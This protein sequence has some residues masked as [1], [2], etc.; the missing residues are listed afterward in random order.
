VKEQERRNFKGRIVDWTTM[1][2][3]ALDSSTITHEASNDPAS[4]LELA[5]QLKE[6]SLSS[7]ASIR[8]LLPVTCAM[9]PRAVCIAQ[10]IF[11]CN[12]CDKYRLIMDANGRYRGKSQ[13][14]FSIRYRC[15]CPNKSVILRRPISCEEQEAQEVSPSDSQSSSVSSFSHS[16]GSTTTTTT[17]TA[18][19]SCRKMK[20][21]VYN[22]PDSDSDSDSDSEDPHFERLVK[23][24]APPTTLVATPV[25][26][27]LAAPPTLGILQQSIRAPT[28]SIHRSIATQTDRTMSRINNMPSISRWSKQTAT[29]LGVRLN[30]VIHNEEEKGEMQRLTKKQRRINL[31]LFG[32]ALMSLTN[33]TYFKR[34]LKTRG[35]ALVFCTF[36]YLCEWKPELFQ[37][38]ILV[39]SRQFLR[40]HVFQPWKFQK[41]IDTNAAGG[42]N[43]ESCNS[44]RNDV[45]ELAS[46]GVIPHGTTIAKYAKLLEQHAVQAYGLAI[47]VEKTRHGPSLS[48]DLDTLLR[49]IICGY[50]LDKFAA[51]ASGHPPVL[52][53]HTLDG[54][55]LTSN[56]GHVT[57][58]TKI[59]DPRAANPMTGI[60]IG[61]SGFFQSRDLCYPA[62]IVFGKDCK[63]LYSDCFGGF[64]SKFH[65][66]LVI[67]PTP[68]YP[69]ELSN[70]QISAP[71]DM[72]S[73]W[74]TTGL[75]GGCYNKKQF[76][77]CCMCTNDL[78]SVYKSDDNRCDLCKRLGVTRCFCHPVND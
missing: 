66:G 63:S 19:Q 11:S 1:I 7:Q 71:Q 62:Q 50:G 8:I 46:T 48:F 9:I 22:V 59:V 41:S 43:Y 28:P 52:I 65:G 44:I 57:A 35:N 69:I 73:I 3:A 34:R 60:H 54:A 45:E 16:S 40:R 6:G 13:Q 55:M 5:P 72:S 38:A 20:A 37:E 4:R 25:N 75:G 61:I 27:I 2:T 18:R 39:E 70:F 12:P 47:N 10:G 29:D 31:E 30:R 21:I 14:E 56:L 53:A 77:Y 36:R 67:P 26:D 33:F 24:V 42:L 58:G 17:T 78:I 49:L 74:K 23:A 15:N 51:T 32:K 76:C 68:N 64:F